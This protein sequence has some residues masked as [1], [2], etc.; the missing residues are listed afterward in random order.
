MQTHVF[1]AHFQIQI[2]VSDAHLFFVMYDQIDLNGGHSAC[3][4]WTDT[5]NNSFKLQLFRLNFAVV[6]V[7]SQNKQSAK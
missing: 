7:T 1:S 2:N 5:P 6:S 4:N 3:V